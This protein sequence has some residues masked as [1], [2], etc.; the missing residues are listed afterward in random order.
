M[1][2]IYIVNKPKGIT[3]FDV[4]AKMRRI[5]ETKKVGHAGTLDPDAVGVLPICVGR[6]TKVIEYLMEEDKAYHVELMLG[7]ATDTQDSSGSVLYEKP[8]IASITEIEETI[9]SF[10]GESMQ[11]PPMYSAI[12]VNGKRLYELARKGLEVERNPRAITISQIDI[13]SINKK[14]DKVIVLFDV[15][16]SKGTYVRTLCNDIGERLN[17]GGHMTSL[18]RTRS[19]PFKLEDSFTLEALEHLKKGN[20]LH[21]AKLSID[22]AVLYMPQVYVKDK[23]AKNLKNG[24]TIQMENLQTGLSRV[25]HENGAFLAIGKTVLQNNRQALKTHKWI[26]IT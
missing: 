15:D 13:S 21:S 23:E 17:C 3:S 25:Y 22:T 8:V 9:K 7:M 1:D 6:A 10:V 14:D 16:C 12:R 4:V 19:G 24:Q 2:G 11:I 18:T 26:D 5:C 20:D